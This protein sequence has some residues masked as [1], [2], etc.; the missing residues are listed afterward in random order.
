M[1]Q[2]THTEREILQMRAG[3]LSARCSL[4][5]D[6]LNANECV[7]VARKCLRGGGGSNQYEFKEKVHFHVYEQLIPASNIVY[8]VVVLRTRD[9]SRVLC[10]VRAVLNDLLQ[11]CA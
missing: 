6:S 10:M 2:Y 5:Q 3:N 8:A 9:S 1:Q 7:C 11:R 4:K